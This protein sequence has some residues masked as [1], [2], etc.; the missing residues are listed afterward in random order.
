MPSFFDQSQIHDYMHCLLDQSDNNVNGWLNQCENFV[1]VRWI[2]LIIISSIIIW[3]A[4]LRTI[5]FGDY[6]IICVGQ[7]GIQILVSCHPWIWDEYFAWNCVSFVFYTK[8]MQKICSF[9]R[10]AIHVIKILHPL[11]FLF[12][13][14]QEIFPVT[15]MY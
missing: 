14:W 9:H 11:N 13:M 7:G 2:S 15:C 12:I 1:P 8:W 5:D 4:G 3:T 10:I 6:W